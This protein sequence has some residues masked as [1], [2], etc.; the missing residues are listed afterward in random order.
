[1]KRLLIVMAHPDDES[2]GPSGTLALYAN[3]GVDVHLLC[4]TNGDA[5]ETVI[6]G[7]ASLS[8]KAR[9]KALT[10]TRQQEVKRAAAIIGISHIDFLNY[11]DG[12]LCNALYHAIAKQIIDKI[13]YFSPQVIIAPEPQGITGHLDH[14]AV[15]MI[16]TYA[17][18]H[19]LHAKK[20]YYV[21]LPQSIVN[22]TE[23]ENY[24]VYFP[25]GYT[26]AAITTR[27]DYSLF[28]HKKIAAMQQ[29]VSQLTDA[30]YL[31]DRMKSTPKVDHFILA[32]HRDCEVMLPE[33][34]LFA[35]LDE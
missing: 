2:F 8:T 6:A 28:E 19:S 22:L 21:C 9:K 35:G 4:V 11:P 17:F 29:H 25:P 3:Q 34:D 33:N 10:L 15:S 13:D 27:I 30:S 32:K 7:Q 20:L 12:Q 26:D 23:H 16:T 24:F 5:S 14:I 1:M 18:L 31:I